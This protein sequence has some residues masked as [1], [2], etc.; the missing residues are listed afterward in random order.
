MRVSDI[1]KHEI[2]GLSIEIVD[3]KNK[4]DVGIKGKVI[5]E[6]KKTLIIEKMSGQKK[7]LFKNNITIQIIINK[8]KVRIKGTC[9]LGRPQDRI[10]T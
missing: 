1:A 7:T 2:I 4:S 6:T 8:Q 9:L 5:D 3:S 10:K